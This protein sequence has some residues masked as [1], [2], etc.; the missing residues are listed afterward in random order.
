MQL[1]Q[2]SSWDFSM[3]RVSTLVLC[4]AVTLLTLALPATQQAAAQSGTRPTPAAPKAA[5]APSADSGLSR[6]VEQLEEQL[7]DMQVVVGT[8]ESLAKGTT[9]PAAG[10]GSNVGAALSGSD[11]GRLDSLETQIRALSAQIEQMQDQLRALSGRRGSLS[12]PESLAAADPGAA[13]AP[14]PG[15]PSAAPPPE[16]TGFGATVV[17]DEKEDEINKLLT[18]PAQERPQ[19]VAAAP[20]A[21]DVS[22]KQLYEQAY[23]YL[24]QRD[25]GAAEQAFEDFL[26][27]FPGDPLGAN[28]QYWLGESLFVRGQYRAAAAAFLKGYQSWGKSPKAPES[29]LKLA[30]SLQRLGQK[31]AACTSFSE[32]TAKFPSAPPHVKSTANAERQRAGCT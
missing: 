7:V 26:K 25:Y 21:D 8:L 27:R 17:T 24:L 22:P 1:T 9:A 14:R 11:A 23:G 19:R 13:T 15:R 18:E 16:R 29:L 4:S 28:A 5:P 30:I 10:R 2:D 31:E 12:Q 32:L 3:R 6:R 20:V